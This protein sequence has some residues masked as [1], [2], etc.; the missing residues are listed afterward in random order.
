MA[1]FS[2]Q[3]KDLKEQISKLETKINDKEIYDSKINDGS[4]DMLQELLED[5]NMYLKQTDP[6]GRDKQGRDTGLTIRD[7]SLQE[8]N[9]NMNEYK[10]ADNKRQRMK[11][12]PLKD[13][14][15]RNNEIFTVMFNILKKQQKQIDDFEKVKSL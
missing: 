8:F 7:C 15:L 3:L 4:F 1:A 13:E 2:N 5:Q 12:I 6:R 10:T 14:V 9:N 11:K